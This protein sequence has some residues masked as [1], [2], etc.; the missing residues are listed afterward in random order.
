[1]SAWGQAAFYSG[2]IVLGA[3][4]GAALPLFG[5]RENGRITIL[6]F[7]AGVMLGAGFF[8]MLPEALEQGGVRV[9]AFTPLGFLIMFLLERY[10]FVRL[11]T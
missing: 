1:M 5:R 2:L 4:A 3:L 10:V 9:L 8:H 11:G 7:A 6:A